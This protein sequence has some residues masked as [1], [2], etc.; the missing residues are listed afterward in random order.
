MKRLNL[1]VLRCGDIEKSRAFY[2]IFGMTFHKH[3]HGSGPEH[4]A[5]ADERSVFELYP[6]KEGERDRTGIGFSSDDLEADFQK[7][8]EPG[9]KPEEIQTTD[10]GRS[11]VVR[12]PDGR[13][14]EIS[15]RNSS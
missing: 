7:L 10:W 13:R 8:K 4:F 6:A 5:H 1:L 15:A 14:V 11:F 3:R 2:E 9:W 12:D